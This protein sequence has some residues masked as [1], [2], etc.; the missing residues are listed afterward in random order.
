MNHIPVTVAQNLDFNVAGAAH[1]PLQEDGAVA[2]AGRGLLPGFFQLFSKIFGP[3]DHAHT[4]AAA[5]EG[6]LDDQRKTNLGGNL[7]RLFRVADGLL[8]AGHNGNASLDCQAAR[9]GLV[10]QQIEQFGAGADKADAGPL[11]SPRQLGVFRE[12]AIAGVNGVH[13]LFLGQR[14]DALDVEVRL[15]RP[16]AFADQIGLVG[17]EAVEGDTVLAGV[18]GDRTQAKL[19]GG[20]QNADGNFT[21]VQCE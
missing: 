20:A 3:V 18:N 11:A 1:E 17:L 14:H 16:L 8:R 4:A 15:H 5:A 13:A 2:E 9:G 12:K 19:V 21:A 6:R 10:A 7:L